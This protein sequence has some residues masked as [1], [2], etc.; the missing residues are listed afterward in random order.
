LSAGAAGEVPKGEHNT[1]R[2]ESR[3]HRSSRIGCSRTAARLATA[4]LRTKVDDDEF[5]GDLDLLVS[6]WPDG[7]DGAEAAELVIAELH[8][9]L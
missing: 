3:Q 8:A 6:T 4:N 2:G 1:F 5:R 9:R 7:Y